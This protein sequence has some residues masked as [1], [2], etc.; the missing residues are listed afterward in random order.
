MFVHKSFHICNDSA[1]LISRDSR[2]SRRRVGFGTVAFSFCVCRLDSLDW[3]GLRVHIA[4]NLRVTRVTA[5]DWY[6]VTLTASASAFSSPFTV[7]TSIVG[8]LSKCVHAPDG[9]SIIFIAAS[10][11][12]R[13]HR[14]LCHR[15]ARE[16]VVINVVSFTA[17]RV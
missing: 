8:M 1:E 4:T 14:C 16:I 17:A 9:N 2:V 11:N 5:V 6:V 7:C 12:L 3:I 13:H 15:C 10:V